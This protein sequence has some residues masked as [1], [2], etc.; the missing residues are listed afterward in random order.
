MA[1]SWNFDGGGLKNSVPHAYPEI[2]TWS[3]SPK[4][5]FWPFLTQYTSRAELYSPA[6]LVSQFQTPIF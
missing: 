4:R 6:D 5:G 1:F 2:D 3:I